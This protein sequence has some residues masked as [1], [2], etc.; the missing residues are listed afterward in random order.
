MS[1]SVRFLSASFGRASPNNNLEA[2]V[3]PKHLCKSK[4]PTYVPWKDSSKSEID[5]LLRIAWANCSHD[6]WPD[7][8]LQRTCDL[9]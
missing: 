3:V 7:V 1:V 5:Y 9:H 8:D 2:R 6:R 4:I